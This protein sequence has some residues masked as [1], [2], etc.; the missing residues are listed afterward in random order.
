MIPS[1]LPSPSI[2]RKGLQEPKL[3]HKETLGFLQEAGVVLLAAIKL[4]DQRAAAV[5]G[6]EPKE[7]SGVDLVLLCAYGDLER[8]PGS[9][10]GKLPDIP[11]RCELNGDLP[12]IPA[13]H[14]Y[15]IYFIVYNGDD[16]SQ[17]DVKYY[18]KNL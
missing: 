18:S 8:L 7:R 9:Q 14:L 17:L 5:E 1:D 13:P 11:E 2:P 6:E 3:L 16:P 12:H 4:G 10:Q 15:K